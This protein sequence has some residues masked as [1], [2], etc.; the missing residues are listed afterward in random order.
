MNLNSDFNI[1]LGFLYLKHNSKQAF[2]NS[3][4]IF[5]R[6]ADMLKFLILG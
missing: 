5:V 4:S 1:F 3:F 2:K 6:L